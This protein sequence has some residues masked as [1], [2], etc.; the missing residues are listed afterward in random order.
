MWDNVGKHAEENTILMRIFRPTLPIR[1]VNTGGL[2]FTRPWK[3][4]RRTV[5]LTATGPCQLTINT[6]FSLILS[7]Q[8]PLLL[9]KMQIESVVTYAGGDS[10]NACGFCSHWHTE[11]RESR[12]LAPVCWVSSVLLCHCTSGCW[13]LCTCFQQALQDW[14]CEAARLAKTVRTCVRE[15][16]WEGQRTAPMSSSCVRQLMFWASFSHWAGNSL[17]RLSWLAS[18]LRDLPL[19]SARIQNA[20]LYSAIVRMC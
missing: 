15:C 6:P 8:Q 17:I 18:T 14:G 7:I 10:C 11:Q 16:A 20:R 12:N 1:T 3:L 9:T 5:V 2:V 19:P 4:Y 13:V